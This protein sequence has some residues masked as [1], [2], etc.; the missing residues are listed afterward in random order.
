MR[1][2]Q[3]VFLNS[4]NTYNQVFI[5]L[6]PNGFYCSEFRKKKYTKSEKAFFLLVFVQEELY[7]CARYLNKCYMRQKLSENRIF[8]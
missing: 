2:T 3:V 8:S 6:F 1:Y 7:I 4:K 5:Y